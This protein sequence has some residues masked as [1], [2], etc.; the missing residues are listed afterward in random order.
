ML[1]PIAKIIEND[2]VKIYS[3][4][5]KYTTKEQVKKA[6]NDLITNRYSEV[7]LD[8]QILAYVN[9]ENPNEMLYVNVSKAQYSDHSRY[10]PPRFVEY[11]SSIEGLKAKIRK[12]YRKE[13]KTIFE[14]DEKNTSIN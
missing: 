12:S 7:Y 5:V 1:F 10:N 11:D 8:N 4:V 3:R 6:I 9:S 14:L 2:K 13:T